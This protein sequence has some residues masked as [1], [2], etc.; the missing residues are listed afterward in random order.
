MSCHKKSLIKC[1]QTSNVSRKNDVGLEGSYSTG[2]GIRD[3]TLSIRPNSFAFSASMNLSRSNISS[4]KSTN[5]STCRGKGG[6]TKQS[7]N[8][9]WI[10][11]GSCVSRRVHS[12]CFSNVE[13]L[14]RE[15]RCQW[16]GPEKNG[17]RQHKTVHVPVAL[18]RFKQVPVLRLTVGGP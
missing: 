18:V 16:P 3:K 7:A 12:V 1:A 10:S 6:I 15:L 5:H 4:E 2:A 11:A 17:L 14:P 9:S 8:R 13:F